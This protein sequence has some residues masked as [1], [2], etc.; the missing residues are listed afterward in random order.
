M[1]I[2]KD[3]TFNTSNKTIILGRRNLTYIFG[4]IALVIIIAVVLYFIFKSK[5]TGVNYCSQFTTKGACN[6]YDTYTNV[7]KSCND[8]CTNRGEECLSAFD[9]AGYPIDPSTTGTSSTCLCSNNAKSSKKC[10]WNKN[11][12]TCIKN[13]PKSCKSQHE[14]LSSTDPRQCYYTSI[15]DGTCLN[16][17]PDTDYCSDTL[18]IKSPHVC[19]P[20]DPEDMK[21]T[22]FNCNCQTISTTGTSYCSS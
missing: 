16:V 9:N 1:I 20:C 12:G 21:D 4:G 7:N 2:K 19:G 6:T 15:Y 22:N 11:T 17:P 5:G 8:Y 18:N 13:N 10:N 3:H 14:C